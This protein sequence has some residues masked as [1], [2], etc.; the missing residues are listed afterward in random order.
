MYGG[1]D[2]KIINYTCNTEENGTTTCIKGNPHDV[3]IGETTLIQLV[4]LGSYL[5]LWNL[6]IDLKSGYMYTKKCQ[7]WLLKH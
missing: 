1:L 6:F 3:I 7:K 5:A 2:P 4:A